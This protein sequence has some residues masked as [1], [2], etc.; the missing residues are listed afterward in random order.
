MSNNPIDIHCHYFNGKYAFRELVEIGWRWLNGNYPYSR[1]EMD[2]IPELGFLPLELSDLANYVAS[3]FATLVRN[4]KQNYRHEQQCYLN[5]QS[6]SDNPSKGP[7]NLI[8]E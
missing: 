4:P 1:D 2:F 6:L 7:S 5:S 3:M 8:G